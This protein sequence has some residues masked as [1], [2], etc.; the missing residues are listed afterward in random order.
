MGIVG[1]EESGIISLMSWIKMVD[2]SERAKPLRLARGA[3]QRFFILHLHVILAYLHN[4]IC[5]VAT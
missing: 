1:V 3:T 5:S 2:K 4:L